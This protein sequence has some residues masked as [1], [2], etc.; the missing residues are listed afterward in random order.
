MAAA[1]ENDVIGI[2]LS[3]IDLDI[4]IIRE[5]DESTEQAELDWSKS[6]KFMPVFTITDIETHRLSSGK[7]K[8]VAI[9]KTLDRG[10]KF[11][12]E[13]YLSSDTIYT[14]H[15]Q[16]HFFVK[17]Q[18]KAS[19]KKVKRHILLSL[20]I[21]TSKV[22]EAKCNCP[23]GASGY[24]NHIM[25]L[26]LELADYSLKQLKSVPK[27]IACTS[28]LRKWGVP[29]EAD[30][31]KEPVMNTTINKRV[32]RKGIISTLYDPRN[33]FD[34]KDFE[35]KM[36]FMQDTLLKK[37]KR[38]GFANCI[39]NPLNRSFEDTKY[40]QFYLGSPLSYQLQAVEFNYQI[41]TNIK[42]EQTITTSKSHNLGNLPHQ[43][44]T[45]NSDLIPIWQP[46]TQKE[47]EYFK[48]M[49]LSEDQ[50]L[51][52]EKE[53][54]QQSLCDKWKSLRKGR[55]TSSNSH[56]IFIRKKLV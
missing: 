24:C 9:A 44:I 21:K 47:H 33:N 17:A 13:R 12:E 34:K 32:H 10:R 14:K 40:G 11:K 16:T 15:D 2:L 6:L 39:T 28:Q 26:L 51:T 19:M 22:A 37:D 56:K 36:N 41:L 7:Q 27:E 18:C 30:F 23:A 49:M 35:S 42:S 54:V 38:I 8:G 29:G 50:I 31:H 55:I 1:S 52:N 48:N 53:T 20:N 3:D 46:F 5:K 43:F 45:N 25:A 4:N